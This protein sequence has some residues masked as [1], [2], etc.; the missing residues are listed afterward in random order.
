MVSWGCSTLLTNTPLTSQ[1]INTKYFQLFFIES[2][3][4]KLKSVL[5]VIKYTHKKYGLNEIGLA[6][7]KDEPPTFITY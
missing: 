5:N 4:Y 7:V 2:P 1:E 6:G 3:E